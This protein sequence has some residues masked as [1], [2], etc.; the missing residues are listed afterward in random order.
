MH[1]TAHCERNRVT[2]PWAGGES[3]VPSS[4][5]E[6]GPTLGAAQPRAL[7]GTA[8][9]GP[10]PAGPLTTVAGP[11]P[12]PRSVTGVKG[13]AD[14]LSEITRPFTQ[15]LSRCSCQSERPGALRSVCVGGHGQ[16]GRHGPPQASS[17]PKGAATQ[18]LGTQGAQEAGPRRE[19]SPC[20][21]PPNARRIRAPGALV[22]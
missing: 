10:S 4:A 19:R 13:E 2:L 22:G 6:P 9:T 8:R 3:G 7:L 1:A 20:P 15:P 11:E 21:A 5:R 16:T 14:P 17:P 12:R 18:T